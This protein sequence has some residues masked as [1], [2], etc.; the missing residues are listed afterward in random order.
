MKLQAREGGIRNGVKPD[1]HSPLG[2][3]GEVGLAKGTEQVP[4]QAL[5]HAPSEKA[6][7]L[8][9]GDGS[10]HAP[11]AGDR[12]GSVRGGKRPDFNPPIGGLGETGLQGSKGATSL[13]QKKD[14]AM[15]AVAVCY[16]RSLL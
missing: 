5:A 15:S 1:Y 7:V 16:P 6:A 4:A 8:A 13:A 12:E 14:T 11:T 3:L 9:F 2:N 10:F